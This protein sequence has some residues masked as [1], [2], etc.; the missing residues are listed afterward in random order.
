V[1]VVQAVEV[2]QHLVQFL[3]LLELKTEAEAAEV[4]EVFQ[5]KAK[6]TAQTAAQELL[7]PVTQALHKKPT[8][9]QLPLQVETQS[10]PLIHLV[11]SILVLLMQL[12]ETLCL[13]VII[14]I[15][16]FYHL[17]ILFRAEQ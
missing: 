5:V 10:T 2:M 11:I 8:A 3:Q 16:H 9:E 17:V 7:S 15:I 1:G 12:V 14:S 13:V 6:A 4:A